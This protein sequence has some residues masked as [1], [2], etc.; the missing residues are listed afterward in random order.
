[1]SAPVATGSL[2]EEA[3][4]AYWREDNF[5][6]LILAVQA[7]EQDRDP[8]KKSRAAYLMK[9][10]V[11]DKLSSNDL[12]RLSV[13]PQ[14]APLC[15]SGYAE[16]LRAERGNDP[17]QKFGR[18]RDWAICTTSAYWRRVAAE[19]AFGVKLRQRDWKYEF[20]K[21][22]EFIGIT[23]PV[24]Q[25]PS[26][27]A[28]IGKLADELE[29]ELKSEQLDEN[30]LLDKSVRMLEL[31][32]AK[33]GDASPTI[34]L[35]LAEFY[36]QRF[37]CA[38]A[39]AL[40]QTSHFPQEENVGRARAI[41]S[42]ILQ[43]YYPVWARPLDSAALVMVA[44]GLLYSMTSE[45]NPKVKQLDTRGNLLAEYGPFGDTTNDGRH[46]FAVFADGTFLIGNRRWRRDRR[47]LG[48]LPFDA[49]A[50]AIC[51]DSEQR[52]FVAVPGKGVSALSQD[53][54]LLSECCYWEG[55]SLGTYR[56]IAVAGGK[57]HALGEHVSSFWLDTGACARGFASRDRLVGAAAN[58]TGDICIASA[59]D[60]CMS[61]NDS[62]NLNYFK[63]VLPLSFLYGLH[64]IGP[65]AADDSS[66]I[67]VIAVQKKGG[68][69]LVKF[70]PPRPKE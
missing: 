42:L 51:I 65:I 6:A 22:L 26:A 61:P 49:S 17:L 24:I 69:L 62:D 32:H 48:E 36:R 54:R 10:L 38:D 59:D 21:N 60:I 63:V 20:E 1:M 33:F 39:L 45:L 9:I 40:L 50:T 25:D 19:A 23:L 57:V 28:R 7:V 29:Y 16:A 3:L 2:Y 64:A 44:D 55:R 34:T 37:R 41:R 66:A 47:L 68:T 52:V 31:A 11:G 70:E 67:Y 53:G 43:S 12:Q 18:L 30:Q 14:I 35:A 4:R 15:I 5:Q 27:V 8:E 58:S 13:R 46:L 56:W